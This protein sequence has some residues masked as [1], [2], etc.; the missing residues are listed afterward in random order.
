[1]PEPIAVA[2]AGTEAGRRVAEGWP[3]M[4]WLVAIQALPRQ[5]ALVPQHSDRPLAES[6]LWTPS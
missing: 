1:M 5:E 6:M 3:S 2:I 4:P